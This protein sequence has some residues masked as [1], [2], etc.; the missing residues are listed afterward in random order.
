MNDV[1]VP[2]ENRIGEEG[3][4]FVI[5]M[6]ALENGRY[7]VAS[8]ACGTIRASYDASVGYA[9]ERE[10]FGRPIGKF[11]LVQQ[12]IA[13]MYQSYEAGQLLC[14]KAGY[15]KNRGMPSNRAVSLAKWYCCDAAFQ[16]ASDAVEVFGAY[17]YSDEYPV[18]RFMRN[19]RAPII[20]EGTREIHTVLQGEYA[21]GYRNDRPV[22]RTLPAFVD[23]NSDAENHAM[24]MGAGSTA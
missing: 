8:G 9:Q 18:F 13:K 11:Q 2:V 19:A 21:L 3:E 20:Y 5:A 7:T 1:R 12:M 22:R 4:G 10:A 14:L 16:A 24:K 23:D 17:G 6:S 15:L